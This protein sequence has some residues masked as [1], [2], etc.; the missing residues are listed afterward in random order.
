[1]NQEEILAQINLQTQLLKEAA[2]TIGYLRDSNNQMATR[3]RMFDD[4]MQVF[5]IYPSNGS[6]LVSG[7]GED[8]AW[9][10]KQHLEAPTTK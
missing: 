4:M 1:M 3:L 9:K 10:I 2:E 5:R 7:K 6:G 8:I